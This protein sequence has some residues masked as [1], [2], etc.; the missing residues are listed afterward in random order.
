MPHQGEQALYLNEAGRRRFLQAMKL[1]RILALDRLL[2]SQT[3]NQRTL[4]QK[5][6]HVFSHKKSGA[7]KHQLFA[8]P[9]A[10]YGCQ[11]CSAF[12]LDFNQCHRQLPKF[13]PIRDIT[14]P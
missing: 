7:G 14:K 9:A 13:K 11:R 12:R 2:I 10:D 4:L 8:I 6:G 1:G 3:E 5:N